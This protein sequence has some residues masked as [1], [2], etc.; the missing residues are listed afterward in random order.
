MN[1]ISKNLI[2]LALFLIGL[3]FFTAIITSIGFTPA[4]KNIETATFFLIQ[5]SNVIIDLLMANAFIVLA[6]YFKKND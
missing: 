3:A 5:K 2:I 4:D 6:I 1:K